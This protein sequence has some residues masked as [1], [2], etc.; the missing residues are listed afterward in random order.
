MRQRRPWV[1]SFAPLKES[2]K[3]CSESGFVIVEF[4]AVKCTV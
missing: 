3:R 4:F 2:F 1:E